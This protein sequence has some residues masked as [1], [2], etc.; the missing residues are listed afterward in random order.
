[1]TGEEPQASV[2]L[3]ALAGAWRCEAVR[4]HTMPAGGLAVPQGDAQGLRLYW[5]DGALSRITWNTSG[6]SREL[7]VPAAS[8]V[9]LPRG[10]AHQLS[11]QSGMAWALA[12]E[13]PTSAWCASLLLNGEPLVS[14]LAPALLPEP[15]RALRTQGRPADTHPGDAL[16]LGGATALIAPALAAAEAAVASSMLAG[17][18]A[19]ARLGAWLRGALARTGPLPPID[20]SA[21]QCHLSR[22]A[23]T[24]QFATLTGLPYAEFMTRWR[25]NA[26]LHRMVHQQ[27]EVGDACALYGYESEASFRKAFRRATGLTPGAAR[28]A[29]SIDAAF[30][31]A[32]SAQRAA[33]PPPAAPPP[34]MAVTTHAQ[35][36]DL[37]SMLSAVIS[38]L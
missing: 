24:R 1:M 6:A 11:P 29:G 31:H 10:L 18:L 15:L 4:V 20:D 5:T 19:H 16:A 35:P 36:P 26:A 37:A 28:R 30:G 14:P 27:M 17:A 12:A 8:L 2:L 3:S 34:R 38:G 21:A 23:F 32:G 13:W 22:A 7:L 25:M 33:S 9:L